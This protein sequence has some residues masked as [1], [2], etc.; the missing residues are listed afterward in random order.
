[1]PV[2]YRAPR[3]EAEL[4]DTIQCSIRAFNG[5]ERLFP[6]IIKHDPWFRLENTRACFV[7]GKAASVVQIF[8][9][10]IHVGAESVL[11]MGGLGSVGTDPEHRRSGY[12]MN[13][14]YDTV[15]YMHADGYDISVLYTGIHSHYARAGWETYPSYFMRLSIPESLES[16]PNVS[17]IEPVDLER[18]LPSLIKLY[19][20]FNTSRTGTLV[21]TQTYWK[22][23]PQWR[24]HNPAYFQVI[25]QKN[26]V[27]AYLRTS[28]SDLAELGY[29]PD[30]E[31]AIRTLLIQFLQQ[32]KTEGQTEINA[33]LPPES[34]PLFESLS[35]KIARREMGS[36]MIRITHFD[37]LLKKLAPL[38]KNRLAAS[39]HANWNGRIRIAYE[40]S[41]RTLAITPNGITVEPSTS[42]PDI[43]LVLNQLQVLKL[44]FG[45]I[46][47]E[48][49]A[50]SNNLSLSDSNIEL[51]D[52]L[53]P[54]DQLFYW[55][56]DGF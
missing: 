10:P 4:E 53:F 52:T 28:G 42:S 31:P 38:W 3:N 2:E 56:A 6:N 17:E 23:H 47:P 44:I 30:A 33:W 18:D 55:R 11:K 35:C 25:R 36:A 12:S 48:Q 22:N 39:K 43:D 19:D 27:I 8:E 13:V 50:F 41:D 29:Q 9:R 54:P 46:R 34:R 49:I 26:S 14:L 21:R 15:R 45:N 32:V 16:V 24:D 7:D 40:A 51:L 37:S 20:D 5:G 1:M